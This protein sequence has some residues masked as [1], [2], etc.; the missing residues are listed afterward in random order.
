MTTTK[1]TSVQDVINQG[2]L[3]DIAEALRLMKAGYALSPIKAIFSGLGS[4]TTVD[5]TTA[6][7]L[8]ACVSHV[9]IVLD[10]DVQPTLPPIGHVKALRPT[11]G[12]A[13]L[14]ARYMGDAGAAAS[15]TVALLSDDGKT[16][17]FEAAVTGFYLEYYP[18]PA[19]DMTSTFAP[20]T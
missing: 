3:N 12:S 1:E 6:A 16:L 15:T 10:T 13:G 4:S 9:G 19:V 7:S 11:T 20:S 8:A 2:N 17:T 14:L 5:I 18:A